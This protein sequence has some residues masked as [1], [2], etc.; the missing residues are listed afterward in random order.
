MIRLLRLVASVML[1]AFVVVVIGAAPAAAHATL[2]TTTPAADAVV[3]DPPTSVSL[4]FSEEINIGLGGV[5]VFDPSGARV[6][7]GAAELDAG[8]TTLS[9]DVEPADLGTHTVVWSVTSDDNHTISGT[10]LFSVEAV[11]GAADVASDPRTAAR[12]LGGVGRAFAFFG[13]L[14]FIGLLAFELLIRRRLDVGADRTARLATTGMAAGA[15]VVVGA[16]AALWAQVA[17]SSGRSLLAAP[18]LVVDA[19]RDTRFGTLGVARILL[20]CAAI[21][22]AFLQRGTGR[23]R[24]GVALGTVVAGGLVVVPPIA[25]HA[26]STTPRPLAV[27]VDAAHLASTGVWIGGLVALLVVGSAS[28]AAGAVVRS[29]S[30]VALLAVAAV[31]ATGLISSYLQVRSV[32]ALTGTGYGVILLIKIAAVAVLIGLGWLNRRRRSSDAA[33]VGAIVR[34]VRVEAAIAAVVIALTATLVNR[35]P[36]RVDLVRSFSG[37]EELAGVGGSVQVEVQ[38]GKVGTND[39]H[40]YFLDEQGAPAPYDAAEVTV[41]REGI[42]A[43]LVK[44]TPVTVDHASAYGVSFPSPGRWTITVTAGREGQ[45]GTASFEVPVR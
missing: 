39:V 15:T 26:W 31:V 14:V 45:T 24:A 32:D 40:L 19:V 44:V 25:G 5:K 34:V 1:A 41:G 6:D 4:T 28:L 13:T 17:I 35:P 20:G 37:V 2:V 3:D 12:L 43:R 18:A 10:V 36:A 23:R 11:T 30:R 27:A 16:L 22:A 21:V 29:F 42:P 38:P 9:V 8:R 33:D 7:R